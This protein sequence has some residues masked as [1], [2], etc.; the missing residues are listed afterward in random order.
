M[1]KELYI[2]EFDRLIL[3]SYHQLLKAMV[4][5]MDYSLQRYLS[6]Y[7]R[8]SELIYTQQ[9]FSAPDSHLFYSSLSNSCPHI[10]FSTPIDEIIYN[11]DIMNTLIK[12]C[13]DNLSSIL[14]T[15]KTYSKMSDLFNF[16]DIFSNFNSDN[17]PINSFFNNK[18]SSY[19]NSDKNANDPHTFLNNMLNPEQRKMYEEYMS[20]LDNIN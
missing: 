18:D 10:S 6:L 12:Y 16:N 7:I 3:P 4:P 8:I 17:N 20:V 15:V 19:A 11:D 5:F 1:S 9:F 2:T 13:P 14:N